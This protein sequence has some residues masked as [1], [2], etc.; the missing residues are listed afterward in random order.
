MAKT[1]MLGGERKKGEYNSKQ[2]QEV[3]TKVAEEGIVL[4]KNYNQCLPL[5][6]KELKKIAVIGYNAKRKQSMGGGSSQ[7]R[8]VL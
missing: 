8:G 3:A 1:N 2:N 4:L 7:V 5:N 6:R